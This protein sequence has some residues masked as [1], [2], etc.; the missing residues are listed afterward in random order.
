MQTRHLE[1]T[2]KEARRSGSKPAIFLRKVHEIRCFRLEV[3]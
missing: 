2:M 3:L 1:N